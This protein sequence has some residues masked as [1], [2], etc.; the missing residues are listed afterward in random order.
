MNNEITQTFDR[1]IAYTARTTVRGKSYGVKCFVLTI[2]AFKRWYVFCEESGED[3]FEYK[4]IPIVVNKQEHKID[5]TTMLI[6][7]I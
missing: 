4:G 5:L 7:E 3:M 2:E 6:K 1:Y